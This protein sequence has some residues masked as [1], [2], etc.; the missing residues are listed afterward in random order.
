MSFN[1]LA[2]LTD[3]EGSLHVLNLIKNEFES[4]HVIQDK[5]I[6]FKRIS[7]CSKFVWAIGSSINVTG[8][9]ICDQVLLFVPSPDVP[10]KQGSVTFENQRKYLIVGY[11]NKVINR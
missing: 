3:S 6:K 9:G 10:I 5:S 4:N 11:C 1:N 7:N 8:D 2:F